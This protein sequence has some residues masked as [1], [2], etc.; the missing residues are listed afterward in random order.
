MESILPND[1]QILNFLKEETPDR[2]MMLWC[3]RQTQLYV[4]SIMTKENSPLLGDIIFGTI[5]PVN[6]NQAEWATSD[7]KL[8]GLLPLSVT[9]NFGR[10]TMRQIC[11]LI[12]MVYFLEFFKKANTINEFTGTFDFI[13]D[14]EA[15]QLFKSIY[16]TGDDT[17]RDVK[18]RHTVS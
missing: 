17:V 16:W 3:R 14:V 18:R 5:K 12:R 2:I 15:T 6:F 9:V 4:D 7:E 1:A 13:S 11:K 10:K 8:L